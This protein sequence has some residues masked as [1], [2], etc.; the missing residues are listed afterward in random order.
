LKARSG[1]TFDIKLDRLPRH[2]K[3]FGE[4]E[5]LRI[6]FDNSIYLVAD[7]SLWYNAFRLAAGNLP[8]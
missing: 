8:T 7:L 2:S 1:L 6:A 5:C 4:T 3:A